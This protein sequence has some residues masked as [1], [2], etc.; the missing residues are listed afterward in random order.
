MPP[1]VPTEAPWWISAFDERYLKVYAH[2]DEAEA[3][4]RGVHIMELLGLG[5]DARVLDVACGE[6][7]YARALGRLGLRMTGVDISRDLLLEAKE[8]SPMLPGAPQYV[9]RDMRKLPFY[10]QFEGAISMFTSF[11]Y[12]DADAEDLATFKGVARA[13]V[14]G[15]RF[16]LDFMN[17][18][19]VRS[20]LVEEESREMGSMRID[21]RRWIDEDAS[22][23]PRVEK[24]LQGISSHTGL[25]EL[26]VYESVRLYTPDE[27]DQLLEQAGLTPVGERLGDVDGSPFDAMADRL[28]RV[29]ELKAD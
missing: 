10:R 25:T 17:E 19:K 24:R 11:G 21:I 18:A 9:L 12:F 8:R 1:A 13:L 4:R 6:G 2:R 14:P 15:G 26:E 20:A 16:V 27:V 23:G 29:A 3:D 5:A 7:R 28:V 22:S